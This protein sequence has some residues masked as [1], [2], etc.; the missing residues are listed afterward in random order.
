MLDYSCYKD[1]VEIWERFSEF[2]TNVGDDEDVME[3]INDLWSE[4][5][6]WWVL[7]HFTNRSGNEEPSELFKIKTAVH[8]SLR[9]MEVME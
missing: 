8:S 1:D 2:M 7:F 3:E 9:D 4:R 6:S 5:K